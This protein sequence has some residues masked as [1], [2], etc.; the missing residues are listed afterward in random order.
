MGWL[1]A[2]AIGLISC[3]SELPVASDYDPDIDFSQYK[4]YGIKL[5]A[6]EDNRPLEI[7]PNAE[8]RIA[9]VIRQEMAVHGYEESGNPDIWISFYLKVSE[10]MDVVADGSRIYRMGPNYFGANWGYGPGWVK[11]DLNTEYEEA[12]LV[13]DMVDAL[14]KQ[15]VWFGT[16][17]GSID[18]YADDAEFK[19]R[20]AVIK[21]MDQFP[22]LAGNGT[23][24]LNKED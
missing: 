14:E 22:F 1:I 23:P 16:C 5:T 15:L 12:T 19:Y 24:Y 9:T 11:N 13:I 7:N 18:S 2:L 6:E 8:K 20:A 21:I 10:K 17:T 3:H 4:T